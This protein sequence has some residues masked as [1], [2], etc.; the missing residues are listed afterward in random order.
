[1]NKKQKNIFFKSGRA[2]KDA[3]MLY[4]PN[5]IRYYYKE[6]FNI[7][8]LGFFIKKKGNIKNTYNN[9]K[10]FE[11]DVKS[12]L[13]KFKFLILIKD[14]NKKIFKTKVLKAEMI[15]ETRKT[16]ISPSVFESKFYEIV[17]KRLATYCKKYLKDKTKKDKQKFNDIIIKNNQLD[18]EYQEW[19]QSQNK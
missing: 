9:T 16:E 8:V 10:M 12:N 5:R 4:V 3:T 7:E 1:M 6:I 18:N 11:I 17:D 13:E 15:K 14:N 2:T 19:K